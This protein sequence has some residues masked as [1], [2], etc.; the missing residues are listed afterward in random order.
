MTPAG[1]WSQVNDDDFGDETNAEIDAMAEFNGSLY[2]ATFTWVCDD[3]NCNTGHTMG[4]QVYRS[5][6]G[7]TW[8]VATAAGGFGSGN[9]YIASMAVFN[10]YLYAGMG[11]DETHGARN[12]AHSRR[13]G[14]DA[15][16]RERLRQRPL[17][18]RRAL[19]G[20]LRRPALRRHP[21]RR[22]V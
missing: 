3:L 8:Q 9:R 6:D 5:A 21:P 2:A 4:P 19:P 7:T 12:L 1:A 10:G 17:Q 13:P 11:G 15:R 22:L 16:R 18:H 14:L 20:G